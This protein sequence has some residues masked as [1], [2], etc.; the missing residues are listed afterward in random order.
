MNNLRNRVQI[1][2]HLGTDPELVNFDEGKKLAKFRI[3]TNDY[4][5]KLVVTRNLSSLKFIHI[6]FSY[7]QISH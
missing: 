6:H 5:I 2:G 7:L 3:A 4:Y 1:I